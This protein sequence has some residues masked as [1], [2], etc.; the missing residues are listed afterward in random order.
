MILRT[1]LGIV[2]GWVIFQSQISNV[3]KQ[4]RTQGESIINSR[5][6][7]GEVL[8][9]DLPGAEMMK[10]IGSQVDG[11]G[12]CVMTSIELAARWQGLEQYRGLRDWCAKFP[13]GAYPQ[14]VDDQLKRFAREHHLPPPAYLQYEGAVPR[15]LL[16]LC[17]KTGRMACITYGRG[18]RYQ[19]RTI[20]HMVCCPKFSQRWGVV[21]DNNFPGIDKYEWMSLE[22]LLNR[23]KWPSGQSWLFVWLE[24]APSP[25]PHNLPH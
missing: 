5:E 3:D 25:I 24:A 1:I 6:H 21:L 20:Q 17:D 9:C 7:G 14:K 13:G 12:M 11:A 4:N 2:C 18:P 19:Q 8:A 10:N 15:P 16:E 23:M 22:E